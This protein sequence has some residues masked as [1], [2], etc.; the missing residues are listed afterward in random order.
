MSSRRVRTVRGAAAFVNR[1]GLALVFPSVDLVLPTLWEAAVGTP[2]VTVFERDATGKR[3][4]TPELAHVWSLHEALARNRLACV[5]KHV[6]NRLALVSLELLPSLYALTGRDGA[7]DDF[8]E[9]GLLAPL[10]LELAETLLEM[11][12]QTGPDLREPI[13]GSEAKAVKRALEA[14]QRK[15]VVTRAGEEE[16]P[17]GWDAALFD[18]AARRFA[19]RLSTLPAVEEAR[20]ALAAAVLR[21]AGEL[22][23]ADTSAVL[24]IPRAEAR[25]VLDGLVEVGKARCVEEDGFE[26]W[27]TRARSGAA[28]RPATP[29]ANR[30]ARRQS[31]GS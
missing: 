13:G 17:Q 7:V 18:L 11:G 12:P 24:G 22:S 27:V 30:R 10:E 26:L 25:R 5:G 16:Q 2:E 3:V 8:R 4:L 21:G 1:T 9:P 31:G 29:A 14:L 23:A 15:L 19:D 28:A 20:P 6:G